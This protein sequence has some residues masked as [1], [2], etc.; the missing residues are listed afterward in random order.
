MSFIVKF[1]AW[2]TSLVSPI[3]LKRSRVFPISLFSSI[4]LHCSFKKAFYFSLLFSETLHSVGYI[5]P[6]LSCFSLLCSAI[7]KASSDNH[8]AFLLFFSLG[9]FWSLTPVQWCKPPS[10]VL[11]ALCLFVT[12]TVSIR[13]LHCIF[14]RDLTLILNQ[15]YVYISPLLFEPPFPLTSHPTPLCHHTAPSWAPVLAASP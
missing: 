2:N 5:F 3:F 8:F 6:F 9:W 13:H 7:C 4:S 10:I 1:L 12:S 15:L 11:Q 14:I